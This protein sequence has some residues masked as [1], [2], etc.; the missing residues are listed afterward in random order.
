M[1]SH[2]LINNKNFPTRTEMNR[3]NE[4][5]SWKRCEASKVCCLNML[6]YQNSSS[7]S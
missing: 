2:Y 3:M 4:V 7:A 6:Q 5:S 1:I